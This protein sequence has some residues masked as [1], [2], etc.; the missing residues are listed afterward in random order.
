MT[1]STF[2]QL[3]KLKEWQVDTITC[4]YV[5]HK[6]KNAP[7][8]THTRQTF[9]ARVIDILQ[10]EWIENIHI[11][12]IKRKSITFSNCIVSAEE[13]TY[14]FLNCSE[15]INSNITVN[16]PQ[17]WILLWVV[18]REDQWISHQIWI[19]SEELLHTWHN[20]F[21][22]LQACS[23]A[24]YAERWK[25]LPTQSHNEIHMTCNTIDI[26]H[27]HIRF[28]EAKKDKRLTAIVAK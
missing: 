28:K 9:P 13:D 16:S 25:S 11:L 26:A 15:Q 24:C 21:P 18:H 27:P 14:D 2:K 22:I 5:W 7:I 20:G 10:K 1:N 3:Y 8:G 4:L 19:A 12:D 6:M 23:Q 17:G